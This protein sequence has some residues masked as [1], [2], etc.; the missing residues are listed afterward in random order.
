MTF[1]SLPFKL[2]KALP[3]L[4]GLVL[5]SVCCSLLPALAA[6]TLELG[7]QAA[8]S[9]DF[10]RAEALYQDELAT[11]PNNASAHYL[12]GNT[13]VSLKRFAEATSEYEKCAALDPTGQSGIYSRQAL[14][15]LSAGSNSSVQSPQPSQ[16]TKPANEL[17]R[18]SVSTI[19]SQTYSRERVE[20]AEESARTQN[21]VDDT[22]R[23]IANVQFEMQQRLSEVGKGPIDFGAVYDPRRTRAA[24]TDECNKRIQELRSNA[25]RKIHDMHAFY[26]TRD[27]SLEDTATGLDSTYAGSNNRDRVK[28]APIGTNIY[29]RNYQTIGDQTGNPIPMTAP[30]AKSLKDPS[31]P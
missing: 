11:H 14:A 25:D 4:L 29:N 5:L 30:F 2:E 1:V 28:L 13:L 23:E 26:K 6:S 17:T 16:S 12:L 21:V 3:G 8:K 20:S 31:R 27:A 10:K 15:A 9:G 22:N 7:E 19:S 18:S 24:I